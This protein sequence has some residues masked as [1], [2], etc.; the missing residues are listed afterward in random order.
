ME[1]VI[2]NTELTLAKQ[3]GWQ[4]GRRWPSVEIEDL[5]SHLTLWLFEHT[6]QVERF[7]SREGGKAQLAL[8][9]KREALRYCTK[10]AAAR[11]GKSVE[12]DNFYTADVVERGLP[13]LFEAGFETSVRQDPNTGRV[14]ERRFDSGDARAII[15]DL[16]RAFQSLPPQ[17]QIVLEMRYRE[18]LTLEDI[19]KRLGMAA[20][21]ILQNVNK[22][23][24][25]MSDY[26]SR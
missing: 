20:K 2:T 9:L 14:V 24:Q 1:N 23:I 11:Q 16:Q 13:F 21:N 4:V 12:R 6:D 17:N 25:L 15:S 7:R 5:R 8:S 18:D 22:S 19:G 26:L 10:E 3:I